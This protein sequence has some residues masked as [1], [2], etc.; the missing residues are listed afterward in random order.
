[1][2]AEIPIQ[3]EWLGNNKTLQSLKGQLISIPIAGTLSKPKL[4]PR[5]FAKLTQQLGG[6]VIEGLIQDKIGGKLDGAVNK[7]LDLLFKGKK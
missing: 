4:D 7:G 2:V 1:M 6:S 3:A 5:V